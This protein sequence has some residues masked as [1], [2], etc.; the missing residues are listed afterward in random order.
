MRHMTWKLSG[1]SW[2]VSTA[3]AI[4]AV[5]E[6]SVVVGARPDGVDALPSVRILPTDRNR[7]CRWEARSPLFPG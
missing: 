6:V 3:V 5:P 4:K 1:T 2:I 7:F